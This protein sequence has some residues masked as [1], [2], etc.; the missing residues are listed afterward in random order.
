MA[1]TTRAVWY[2]INNALDLL[3]DRGALL[4]VQTVALGVTTVSW[5]PYREEPFLKADDS[6][7]DQ[8]L[9]WLAAGQY[10]AM[11]ADGSL[12]QIAYTVE[13]GKITRHRLNYVPCPVAIDP[14][15]TNDEPIGDLVEVLVA[16]EPLDSVLLRSSVRFD[17]DAA[18]AKVGHPASH[19]TMNGSDCRIAC[20]APVHPHRFLA[21]VFQHFYPALYGQ[22]L[23]WF[24]DAGT[25]TIDT[26]SLTEEDR[27]TIHLNWPLS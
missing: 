6:T 23:A 2:S 16:C 12:L 26:R 25:T 21:F 4:Y 13:G 1:T 18:S 5:H 22:E 15:V 27:Q 24:T 17:Y 19:L 20:V 3:F 9:R 11:L 8:Y 14:D 10:S 7:I